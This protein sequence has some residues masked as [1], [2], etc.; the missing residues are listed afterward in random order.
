MFN[1]LIFT[2]MKVQIQSIHFDADK[3]LID[4]I[5][6]KVSKLE[7]FFDRIVSAEVFLKLDNS[8]IENKIVEIKILIPGNDVIAKNK[9]I[10]FEAATDMAVDALKV[11]LKKHKEKLAA[12]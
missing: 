2:T 3:K 10:S 9:S 1:P 6:K 7:T 5:E 4:Y 12:H 11:Q 8:T